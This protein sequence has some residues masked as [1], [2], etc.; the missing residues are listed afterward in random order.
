MVRQEPVGAIHRPSG[1]SSGDQDGPKFIHCV[2][3]RQPE[4]HEVWTFG[5]DSF[6]CEFHTTARIEIGAFVGECVAAN[7]LTKTWNRIPMFGSNYI[8]G[9]VEWIG[10]P[11]FLSNYGPPWTLNILDPYDNCGGRGSSTSPNLGS[12]YGVIL[13]IFISTG[14]VQ[15]ATF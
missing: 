3:G 5:E 14:I 8:N 6:T 11:N 10:V 1:S 4:I 7:Y 2:D 13:T 12:G 15:I 9:S